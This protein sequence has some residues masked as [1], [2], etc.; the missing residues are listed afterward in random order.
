M[1]KSDDFSSIGVVSKQRILVINK[2]LTF[3][4]KSLKYLFNVSAKN[5]G[6]SLS[7][8]SGT[9]AN[10]CTVQ[11]KGT[12]HV[13]LQDGPF[14]GVFT[15][16]PPLGAELFN[17]STAN[18]GIIYNS[19]TDESLISDD[20]N[21]RLEATAWINNLN[22]NDVR[23]DLLNGMRLLKLLSHNINFIKQGPKSKY[24]ILDKDNIYRNIRR[25]EDIMKTLSKN[26]QNEILHITSE[27]DKLTPDQIMESNITANIIKNNMMTSLIIEDKLSYDT[28]S[29]L[30]VENIIFLN[31]SINKKKIIIVDE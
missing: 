22:N 6:N 12:K 21:E 17:T 23:K 26:Q 31:K 24:V 28:Y 15:S 8:L 7:C 4:P 5:T 30:S 9:P 19:F 27:I 20:Y 29:N 2:I 1:F 16:H 18:K 13:G 10:L 14:T 3:N 11:T 25:S